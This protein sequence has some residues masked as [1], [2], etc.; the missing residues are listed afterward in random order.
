MLLRVV[1]IFMYQGDFPLQK[2]VEDVA[3]A[4]GIPYTYLNRNMGMFVFPGLR[5]ILN[6]GVANFS[7][8]FTLT[9]DGNDALKTLIHFRVKS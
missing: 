6:L 9:T 4:S 5:I 1:V 8:I 2:K 7:G 3:I